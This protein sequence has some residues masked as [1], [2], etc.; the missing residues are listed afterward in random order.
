MIERI[1]VCTWTHEPRWRAR[2]LEYEEAVDHRL[3]ARARRRSRRDDSD[4]N[5]AVLRDP[6]GRGAPR[7]GTPN[8]PW[9]WWGGID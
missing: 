5:D 6:C 2:R 7:G 4:G 3:R 9:P 1:P 8:P